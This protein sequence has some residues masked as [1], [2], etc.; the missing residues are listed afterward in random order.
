VV[1]RQALDALYNERAERY[2]QRRISNGRISNVGFDDNTPSD[3]E[4]PA[5]SVQATSN[6]QPTGSV[7]TNGERA[8]SDFLQETKPY[9]KDSSSGPRISLYFYRW[10][11]DVELASLGA[12]RL[13][14]PVSAHEQS[15]C[16]E[17]IKAARNTGVEV[18]YWLPTITSGNYEK[19]VDRFLKKH[20]EEGKSNGD[21]EIWINAGEQEIDGVMVANIGMLR[22]L[23]R[24]HSIR[25]AGDVPLNLFNA[26]SIHE[27]AGYGIESAAISHE[28]TV[29]QIYEM[30]RR[31][32][33]IARGSS[34]DGE[35]R[36]YRPDV[37]A[38]VYGRLALMTSEYCPVGSV[39]GGFTASQRCSGC[40]SKEAYTLEDRLGMR[41][42]VL[43]DSI[44]CTTTILNSNVLFVPDAIESLVKAGISI[45]RLNI[46]DEAPDT[47]K[48]LI[49]L[50]RA[51][52][53][54]N[55][56][57]RAAFGGLVDRIKATGFTKGHYYR[58]V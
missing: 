35:A 36:S 5:S 32:K 55:V 53:L 22:R 26:N 19:I 12:D 17:A 24:I 28:V 21:G 45:F 29:Q 27:A 58:G 11:R 15:Q 40:C 18:F 39:E 57:K 38:A 13:Y 42:P 54:G 3:I 51:S 37:E 9:S 8:D 33:S 31:L 46:W 44:N 6:A 30:L 1:R 23:S 4:K 50:Y 10:R 49:E 34:G 47:I 52:A 20:I 43:C 7:Q 41:F 48:D 25:L 2:A 16:A 56:S 14:L